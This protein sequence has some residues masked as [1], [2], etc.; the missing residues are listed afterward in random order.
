MHCGSTLG[1]LFHLDSPSDVQHV[2]I[3]DSCLLS[4]FSCLSH[5]QF[6]LFGMVWLSLGGL[7]HHQFGTGLG[8][9]F[10]VWFG[11]GQFLCVAII[12]VVSPF[13]HTGLFLCSTFKEGVQHSLLLVFLVVFTVVCSFPWVHLH[14]G[15][16]CIA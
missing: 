12:S 11:L 3:Q 9:L 7:G 6:G 5:H 2:H 8:R 14:Q 4:W 13:W 10:L 15:F 1:R 16:P